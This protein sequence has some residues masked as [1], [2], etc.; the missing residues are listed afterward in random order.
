VQQNQFSFN[1]LKTCDVEILLVYLQK[2]KNRISYTDDTY[3]LASKICPSYHLQ[4]DHS[5]HTV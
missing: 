1:F 3:D 5:G 4:A 2:T